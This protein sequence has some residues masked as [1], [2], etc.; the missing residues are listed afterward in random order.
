[1]LHSVND[2]DRVGHVKKEHYECLDCGNET[3]VSMS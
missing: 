2:C 1:M 3:A